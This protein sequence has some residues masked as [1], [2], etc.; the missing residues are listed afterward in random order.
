[1]SELFTDFCRK[2]VQYS[3][4]LK[5]LSIADIL[6]YKSGMGSHFDIKSQKIKINFFTGHTPYLFK[7]QILIKSL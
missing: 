6:F 1:M 4:K 3:I 5:V 2:N 7:I